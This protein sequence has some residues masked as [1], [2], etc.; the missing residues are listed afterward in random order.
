MVQLRSGLCCECASEQ[1]NSYKYLLL[2]IFSKKRST[3]PLWRAGVAN[4][5]KCENFSKA[6]VF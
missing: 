6:C 3:Q 5:I 2:M 4:R 1:T